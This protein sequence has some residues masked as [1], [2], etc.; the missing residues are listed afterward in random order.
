VFQVQ[1]AP[2]VTTTNPSS[3]GQGATAQNVQVNGSNFF[4]SNTGSPP[5][6]SF[7]PGITVNT[8][9]FNSATRV[10]AN[11]TIDQT[12]TTGAR[13]V[14]VTNPDG[15]TGSC[16]SCFTVNAGPK[17]TSVRTSV[18]QGAT[19]KSI[20]ITGTGFQTGGRN[21]TVTFSG[22]GVSATTAAQTASSSTTITM[23][24]NAA[25]NA[26]LGAHDVTGEQD[27]SRRRH[28]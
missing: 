17:P 25:A 23:T 3:L 26:D 11:V 24:V 21:V 1:A 7:G 6:V 5:S 8:V 16:A 9:T 12:A 20:T 28:L 10:T 13:G 22:S 14:T 27:G 15:T 4:V 18:G 2:T 19:S